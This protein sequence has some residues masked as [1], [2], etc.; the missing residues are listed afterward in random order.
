MKSK[1]LQGG[2]FWLAM[3]IAASPKADLLNEGF[4]SGAFSGWTVS[5]ETGHSLYYVDS[6]P[7]PQNVTY[8]ATDYSFDP[9]TNPYIVEDIGVINQT[10]RFGYYLLTP[11]EGNRFLQLTPGG[12]ITGHHFEFREFTG[13]DQRICPLDFWV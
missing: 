10:H 12:G 4:E 9:L 8:L 5:I 3:L 11:P 7:D 2:V 1:I 6:D 13:P